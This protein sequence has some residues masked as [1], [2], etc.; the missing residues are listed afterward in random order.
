MMTPS[1]LIALNNNYKLNNKFEAYILNY[2]K[3]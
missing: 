1:V 2:E 3:I